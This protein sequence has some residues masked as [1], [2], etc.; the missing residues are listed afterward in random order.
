MCGEGGPLGAKRTAGRVGVCPRND[1]VL[2]S[3]H[4]HPAPHALAIARSHPPHHSLTLAGG[5][6]RPS[7]PPAGARRKCMPAPAF[8]CELYRRS[9]SLICPTSGTLD[10][11]SSPR[12]KDVLLPFFGNMCFHRS[13]PPRCR[14]A[15]GQSSPDVGR[16]GA[17]CGGRDA[18]VRAGDCRAA[19]LVSDRGV[20]D[21]RQCRGRR[22]RVVLAP[23]G[24]R[25]GPDAVARSPTGLRGAALSDRRG[26]QLQWSPGRARRKP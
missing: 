26:Q 15:C 12:A 7:P 22:S 21:E 9:A 20:R 4:P 10:F 24:R 18:V 19:R 14:G 5:G 11:L 6:M 3:T 8:T 25:Q 2:L 23:H 1:R 16:G 17:G 13:I